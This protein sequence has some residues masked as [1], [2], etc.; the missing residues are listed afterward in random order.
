MPK[1]KV[2][3]PLPS[4][5]PRALSAAHASRGLALRAVLLA[6]AATCGGCSPRE[7]PDEASRAVHKACVWLG[8]IDEPAP[9]AGAIEAV[10]PMPPPAPSASTSSSAKID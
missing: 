5:V 7:W 1:R 9:V 10:H 2:V 3:A 6:A 8:V 4:P